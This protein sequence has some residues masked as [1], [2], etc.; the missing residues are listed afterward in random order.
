VLLLP[1]P[2]PPQTWGLTSHLQILC[3]KWLW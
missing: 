1:S 2:I 3:W